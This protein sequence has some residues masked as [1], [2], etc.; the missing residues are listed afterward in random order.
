M[1]SGAQLA[2]TILVSNRLPVTAAIE[3]GVLRLHASSGGLA[4]GLRGFRDRCDAAWIGWPGNL[5]ELTPD[6]ERALAGQ[7]AAHRATPVFL[8]PEEID[9]YYRG[10][11]NGVIWPLFH[12]LL[13]E[14]PTRVQGWDAFRSVS[15]KFART[16]AAS[17]R[18]GDV[19]WI[20]DFQMMLV[21]AL[22]RRLLPDAKI[23]FFLHVPFPSSEVFSVCPWRRE[24]LEGLLGAD[25]I[26]FHTPAYVR[27]F[28]T[29]LRRILGVETSM[30]TIRRDGR[31]V[32]IGVFPMGVDAQAWSE[33]AASAGVR[34]RAETI[35]ADAGHRRLIV[36]IDRLD[37]TKGLRRRLLAMEE[38]LRQDPSLAE[39]LR[40]I[41][42]TVPSRESMKPYTSLRDEIDGLVGRINSTYATSSAVPIHHIHHALDERE[43]AALYRAA[44]VM[45]VTPLR[46]GMNLVAK[47]FVASRSDL[48]GVL[49]LSEFAGAAS[50]LGDALLINPYDVDAVAAAIRKAL[51]MDAAERTRRMRSLRSRVFG[52][53]VQR[54]AHSFIDELREPRAGGG[55]VE[56]FPGVSDVLARLRHAHRIELILDYDG[57]LVPFART[58]DAAAPDPQL[59]RLLSDLGSRPDTAVHIVTGRSRESIGRWL[60]GLPLGISAEHGLWFRPRPDEAWAMLRPVSVEWKAGL[61][62]ILRRFVEAT[63][64]SFV[65]EKTASLVWHYRLA[66]DEFGE[67]QSRE[68]RLLLAELLSNVPVEIMSAHKAVEIKV[69]GVSKRDAVQAL[70]GNAAD[71]TVVAIGD[72]QADEACYAVLPER[73]VTVHVN[74]D[75]TN[76]DYRVRDPAEVR[77]ILREIAY[78]PVQRTAA[79]VAASADCA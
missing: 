13:E 43:I 8:T 27:H 42:V 28:T 68:L 12:Y 69:Q 45:L 25:L 72:D 54:W 50:E 7:L 41:Q 62:P 15:E 18:D 67:R 74:G 36:G 64:G 71:V 51:A 58:P 78:R 66:D 61:R 57:T 11:S 4:T 32:R 1:K 14:I 73:S 29:S 60:G 16:A 48:G 26:G 21:P 30:G 20:H 77:R 31:D 70:L 35:R 37:Y 33:R 34:Q 40:L 5:P 3:D 22:L 17:Y 75:S 10:V 76:A 44:D 19:V 63:P 47:E 9:G 53:D 49:V 65:E 39:T 24:L 23:G 2:R 38:L 55:P 52:Q 59:L 6:D 46:D 79:P 56:Q